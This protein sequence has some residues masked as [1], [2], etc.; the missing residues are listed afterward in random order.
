MA[1]KKQVK[2][3]SKRQRINLNKADDFITNADVYVMTEKEYYDI[4]SSNEKIITELN[5]RHEKELQNISEL[6]QKQLSEKDIKI[7]Q[8]ENDLN[9][10]RSVASNVLIQL[11][12]LSLW[13]VIFRSRHKV[14]I[15]DFQKSIWI[16]S[17][18]VEIIGNDDRSDKSNSDNEN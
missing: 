4:T 9:N 11:N 12:G 3:Y 7:T 14:L 5:Q 8:L 17:H 6:Y 15:S 2:E 16:D 10:I 13:D 1:V 18:D